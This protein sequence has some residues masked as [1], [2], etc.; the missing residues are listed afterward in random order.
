MK[1]KLK[2]N[3]VILGG[4]LLGSL[5]TFSVPLVRTEQVC[6]IGGERFEDLDVPQC[7]TNKFVMF[8]K[9]F[10]A[11]E[12]EKYEKI[13][14]SKEYREIPGNSNKYYYLAKFYELL[15]EVSD[16]T[17]GKTY[18]D[19]YHYYSENEKT[20]ME[21]L[22]QGISYLEKAVKRDNEIMWD[23]AKLY[24]EAEE[25]IKMNKLLE[26][27][28]RRD[29]GKTAEFYYNLA[30]L[31][32]Y[33]GRYTIFE[34]E[35]KDENVK[36]MIVTKA[37]EFLQK[38]IKEDRKIGKEIEKQQLLRQA[39]LYREL[40]KS[41]EIDVLF[42]KADKK[43]WKS[44][45]LFYMDEPEMALG[46]VYNE[47]RIS[48]V[49]DLQQAL[50]YADKILSDFKGNKAERTEIL[51]IKAEAY[52]RLGEFSEAEKLL[53]EIDSEK[54]DKMYEFQF[55]NIR[56]QVKSKDKRVYQYIPPQIMY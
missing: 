25:Y 11:E 5:S 19:S 34:K 20:K 43:F 28:G 56:R 55:E 12:L 44:I 37:L 41:N 39:K 18:F 31:E 54:I 48:T 2:L 36:K 1:E 50:V 33:D 4:L 51:L 8:K 15:G 38:E 47:K 26:K 24:S 9:K 30:N 45:S 46:N 3:R 32:L 21:S 52:R 27:T 29:F 14:S 22:Q 16:K 13:I 23:L 6:P 42:A 40:D 7:P 53:K 49:K 17:L 35:I 10:T